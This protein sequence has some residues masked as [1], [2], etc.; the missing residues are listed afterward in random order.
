M[1]KKLSIALLVC[2][3]STCYAVNLGVS[4]LLESSP[5]DV[6]DYV[7][8]NKESS[9]DGYVVKLP[10]KTTDMSSKKDK[11][12][13]KQNH[14]AQKHI[15]KKKNRST[16][17]YNSSSYNQSY[18]VNEVF[19]QQQDQAKKIM[20]KTNQINDAAQKVAKDATIQAQKTQELLKAQRAAQA[21]ANA[22][23]SSANEL[24]KLSLSLQKNINNS[25]V[26]SVSNNL[27]EF[28]SFNDQN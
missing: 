19:L 1:V 20:N 8:K 18:D 24:N 28:E 5:S 22:T 23:I 6:H 16:S 21:S 26:E 10:S 4:P 27:T 13:N 3:I 17:K 11:S 2:C 25:N 7:Q 15:A 12:S 9:E 14:K